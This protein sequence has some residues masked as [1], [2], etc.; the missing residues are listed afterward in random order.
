M[1]H[2]YIK[3]VCKK[4]SLDEEDSKVVK[5]VINLKRC[6]SKEKANQVNVVKGRLN[7]I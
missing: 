5:G 7:N 6:C 3:L 4:I 1:T 2:V